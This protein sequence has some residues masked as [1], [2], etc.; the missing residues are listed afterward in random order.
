MKDKTLYDKD[1]IQSLSPH[2]KYNP[3]DILGPYNI[4]FLYRTKKKNNNWYGEF[5]CPH[6]HKPFESSIA[7]ISSGSCKMCP[8]CLSEKQREL[9]RQVGK[10]SKGKDYSK[11]DNPFYSFIEPT[12]DYILNS[13]GR[14]QFL[15]IIQCKQCKRKYV[16]IPS[17]VISEKRRRGNNPCSCYNRKNNSKGILLIEQILSQHRIDFIKEY[18]FSDCISDKQ[19]LMRFDFY[20]PDY[21]CCI[22]YDGEQ[23]FHSVKIF[24]GNIGNAEQ[25]FLLQQHYDNIKNKYCL[26]KGIL[27][28]R[29]PYFEYKD[30]SLDYLKDRGLNI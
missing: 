12:G 26:E 14:R 17:Q 2:F 1:S 19:A 23:H 29:I 15:W 11:V 16:D 4:L 27:L 7:K 18:S 24:K 6:C 9:G 30:I 20:L 25:N 28:I 3:G 13:K 21:N 10:I 5:Q 22:E 8:E